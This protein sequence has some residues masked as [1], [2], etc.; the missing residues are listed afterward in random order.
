MRGASYLSA[1]ASYL[2]VFR[3]RYANYTRGGVR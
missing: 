2:S 3:E 1:L